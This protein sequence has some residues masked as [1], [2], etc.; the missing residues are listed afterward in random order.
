MDDIRYTEIL[1]IQQGAIRVEHAYVQMDRE[2]VALIV[3]DFASKYVEVDGDHHTTVEPGGVVPVIEFI[4]GESTIK[5]DE[6]KPRDSVTQVALMNY[7]GWQVFAVE[8]RGRYTVNVA[9]YKQ[10]Q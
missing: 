5:L 9:L 2:D 8:R 10:L 3:I 6:S 7:E 1:V 4:A